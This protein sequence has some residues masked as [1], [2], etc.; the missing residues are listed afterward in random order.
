M[1]KSKQVYYDILKEIG[2]I[3]RTKKG[4]K[5]IISLNTVASSIPTIISLENGDTIT[6]RYYVNTF[7]IYFA[8]KA[9]T[10]K[11]V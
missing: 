11:K 8:S 2:I 3:L 6:S 4:I 5:F 9:E 7:N 1:K 10:T